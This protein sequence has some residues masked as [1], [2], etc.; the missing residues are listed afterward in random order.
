[1]T[2][3]LSRRTCLILVTIWILSLTAT[4]ALTAQVRQW[5]P[6][7]PLPEPI[8]FSGDDIG[9]RVEGTV[10][11]VPAGKL[12]IRSRSGQWVEPRDVPRPATLPL[13]R[14]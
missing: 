10:D 14:D 9:F 2:V 13:N 8:V 12:V 6:M 4:A 5:L 1:M 7:E 3:R 11:G